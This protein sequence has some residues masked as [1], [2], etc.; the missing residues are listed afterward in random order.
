MELYYNFS[1]IG[2]G[3][4]RGLQGNITE[5]NSKPIQTIKN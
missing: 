2:L 5:N 3:T 1:G 4:T